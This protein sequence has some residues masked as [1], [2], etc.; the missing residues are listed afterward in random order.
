MFNNYFLENFNSLTNIKDINVNFNN[1]KQIDYQYPKYNFSQTYHINIKSKYLEKFNIQYNQ[2]TEIRFKNLRVNK[3]D[4]ITL[5]FVPDS[6]CF[7]F[8]NMFDPYT[9]TR[10]TILDPYGPL[11]FNPIDLVHYFYSNRTQNLWINETNDEYRWSG[12]PNDGIGAGE[13]FYIVNR[14]FHPEWYL[15]RLPIYHCY[16]TSDHNEQHITLGPKL[17]NSEIEQIDQ[18]AQKYKKEYRKKYKRYL[19]SLKLI[20]QYYDVAIDKNPELSTN[21][22]NNINDQVN[23]QFCNNNNDI[24]QDSKITPVQIDLGHKM[25]LDD[26]MKLKKVPIKVCHKKTTKDN[27]MEKICENSSIDSSISSISDLDTGSNLDSNSDSDL[28]TGSNLD[29]DSVLGS[30]TDRKLLKSTSKP[31]LDLDSDSDLES[32]Y[33]SKT[34]LK[35]KPI[36]KPILDIDPDYHSDLDSEFFSNK[37][38]FDEYSLTDSDLESSDSEYNLNIHDKTDF[39]ND[40]CKKLIMEC[41]K[42]ENKNVDTTDQFKKQTLTYDTKGNES[43][44]FNTNNVERMRITSWGTIYDN[45]ETKETICSDGSDSEPED[46]INSG[47]W[48]R[49]KFIPFNSVYDNNIEPEISSHNNE[50]NKDNIKSTED[51]I[52]FPEVNDNQNNEINNKDNI[53]FP[54]V[55]DNQNNEINNQNIEMNKKVDDNIDSLLNN[56]DESNNEMIKLQLRMQLIEERKYQYNLEAVKKLLKL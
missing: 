43:L 18:V 33:G 51:N 15:F 30:K 47:I 13:D 41:K 5:E 27:N 8:H 49:V 14:G 52:T 17:L 38:I 50:I 35:L 2:D 6:C 25:V 31:V 48:K 24:S 36:S 10:S 12:C 20:K 4:P 46:N 22:L 32:Y 3:I 55:D 21:D 56:N 37:K 16:L 7:Q 9:G 1:S 45:N 53:T 11:C 54:E 19:P 40:I 34:D 29:S 39:K 26:N 42:I 28:D 44:I 23:K